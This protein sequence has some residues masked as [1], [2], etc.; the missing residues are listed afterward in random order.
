MRTAG[1]DLTPTT[2]DKDMA[3]D[4]HRQELE[5][6]VA[7][8]VAARFGGDYRAAFGHYDADGDGLVS[9]GELRALLS[10]AGVG[11]GLTRWAWATAVID[12][13]DADGDGHI[14]WA[15]FEAV[16]TVGGS[17]VSRH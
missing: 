16:S 6:K 5:G 4:E 9:K 11:S 3:S 15:E 12:E 13:L 14:S 17:D 1:G 2:G 7:A 8:L 10:D